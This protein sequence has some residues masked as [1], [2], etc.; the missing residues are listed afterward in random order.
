[1][2][3]LSYSKVNT[4]KECPRKYKLY[5][6]DK[7]RPIMIKSALIFGSA[8]DK[9]I[10]N[11][12]LHNRDTFDW[13]FRFQKINDEE[14]YIPTSL[15][16]SYS[17]ADYDIDLLKQEDLEK[18]KDEFKIEEIKAELDKSFQEKKEFGL[19]R[20]GRNDAFR[21]KADTF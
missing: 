1:M 5:Y 3:H 9:A 16:V 12:L 21:D 17:N 10:E 15:K 2:N 19:F 4:Y 11:S 18:L 13:D 7:F 8:I 20:S 14:T 6:I